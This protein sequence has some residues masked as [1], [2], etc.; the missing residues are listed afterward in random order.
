MTT[1]FTT[2]VVA[3]LLAAVAQAGY[4]DLYRDADFKHKNS[5][6]FTC[7]NLDNAITSAKWHGLPETGSYFEGGDALITFN[8]GANCDGKDNFWYINTQSKKDKYFPENF[9]LDGINDDISSSWC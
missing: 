4:V 3:A 7:D 5:R 9:Q 6:G 2:I 1:I 8:T